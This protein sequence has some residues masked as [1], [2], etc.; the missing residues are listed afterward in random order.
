[1]TRWMMLILIAAITVASLDQ[2][3]SEQE[4][5]EK[6]IPEQEDAVGREDELQCGLACPRDPP[7]ATMDAEIGPNGNTKKDI[8]P[9]PKLRKLFDF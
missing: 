1:M 7:V 5:P 8:N 4:I 6:E 3:A 2:A 9:I